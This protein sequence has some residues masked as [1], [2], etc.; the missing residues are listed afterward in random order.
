ML[1]LTRHLFFWDPKA[2]YA[3][4]YERALYNHIL[5]SQ[6]PQTGMMVYMCPVGAG[7]TKDYCTPEDSFWCCTGT[8]VEN[9]AKY[10]ESV[11][12]H[13]GRTT[14]F[15]NLFI[16][17]ELNW[18]SCGLK[19]RQETRY[20]EEGHTR[21][22]FTCAQPVKLSVSIRR[23]YWAVSGFEVRV[24]GELQP[25]QGRPGSYAVLTRTWKSG[26][27][28]EITM[29]F[30]LRTEGFRD[31]SRRAGVSRRSAGAL[32]GNALR[33]EQVQASLPGR[34]GRAGSP[35]AAVAAGA[36]PL[37]DVCRVL[38]RLAF[39]GREGRGDGR[40]GAV[41]QGARPAAMRG[42]LGPAHARRVGDAGGASKPV[43]AVDPRAGRT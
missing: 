41:L 10:G 40:P 12:F 3:D 21:L 14:L 32:R 38:G 35:A 5:A 8:G 24:N 27:G 42:L 29:P 37:L 20:P 9:H 31:N 30:S 4:Y 23:P 36:R 19:L 39:A 16:P 34:R 2:E 22:V 1:K 33:R 6:N 7:S 13:Q 18:P 17:S 15:V 26:D 28:V 11:Y 43:L 25:D